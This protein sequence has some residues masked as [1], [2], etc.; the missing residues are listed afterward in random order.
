MP[1][2]SP[3]KTAK[4]RADDADGLDNLKDEFKETSEKTNE[5]SPSKTANVDLLAAVREVGDS[6]KQ[7]LSDA[8]AEMKQQNSQFS[9][10]SRLP[11][12]ADII[13]RADAVFDRACTTTTECE[14]Q[15]SVEAEHSSFSRAPLPWLRL[16]HEA[17]L[18]PSAKR[19]ADMHCLPS[20]E[21]L[22]MNQD[23]DASRCQSSFVVPALLPASVDSAACLRA[24]VLDDAC[25]FCLL[26]SVGSEACSRASVDDDA[27]LCCC[28]RGA[29]LA[30]T[31]PLF[32][33]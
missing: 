3:P 10:S 9:T 27:C 18:S 33:S 8:E 31:L 29:L 12:T 21:L 4:V 30:S 16:R 23:S 19:D 7:F 32:V 26:A 22:N 28:F 6:L 14:K 15:P 24:F 1:E 20:G 2:E 11:S 17:W 25:L 13:S 5:G